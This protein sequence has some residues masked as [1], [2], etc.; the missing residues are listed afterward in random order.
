MNCLL[1]VDA[2]AALAAT[3]DSESSCIIVRYYNSWIE[4]G[5][6]CIQMELCDTSLEKLISPPNKLDEKE[7]FDVLRDILLALKILHR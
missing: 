4:D 2:L 3:E 1:Y 6:I 5:Y 7:T